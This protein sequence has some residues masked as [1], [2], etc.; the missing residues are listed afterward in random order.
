MLVQDVVGRNVS[1][2]YGLPR[3]GDVQMSYSA[4]SKAQEMLGWEPKVD[5]IDGLRRT[6]T[7]FED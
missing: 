5:L 3:K 4:I 7:W 1:V 6:W 2:Q